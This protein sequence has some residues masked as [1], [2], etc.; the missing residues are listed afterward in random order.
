LLVDGTTNLESQIRPRKPGDRDVRVAHAEL[1]NDVLPYFVRRRGRQ[2]ENRRTSKSRHDRAQR[3]IIRTEIVSPLTDA[4]RFIHDEER[5][6]PREQALEEIAVLE[7]F[8]REVENLAFTVL[9][10]ARRLARFGGVE[11]RVHGERV[12]PRGGQLVLLVLHQCDEGAHH[13]REP[14]QHQRG[15]LV[16]D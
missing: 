11:M 6:A 8:R 10:L 1:A 16:N 13:H 15:K 2:C 9:D 3:Q 5:H 12:D 14:L 7:P 4:V